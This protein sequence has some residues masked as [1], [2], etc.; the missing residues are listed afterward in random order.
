MKERSAT[1]WS[2]AI[3]QQLL[4]RYGV[5]FRETAHAENLPGGF[6]AIYDVMKA[7]EESGKIRRGYFAADLGATQFAM[8]AAVDLLRS[9]RV[10]SQGDKTEMLQLAAT[11]P[12]NPYGALMRWPAAPDAGSSLTRSVGAR[13]ILC[14]GALVAYLRRGNPNLQVFLPEEEPQRS[15]VAR[16]LA[17]FLVSRVQGQEDAQ[18][19]GGMLIAAVNGV[20]VAEHWMARF[21]LD[22]GFAAGAMGFNVRRGFPPL[23]GT[24]G[25]VRAN[26]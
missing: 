22:A 1:E 6:S 19:R 4:T 23:P 8:P 12:A 10:T 7:L 2:H 16:S 11:D 14:D 5:V 3:A 17:E 20:A 26:A 13:V 21:L 9:L 25:E 15:Q 24:R 18:G